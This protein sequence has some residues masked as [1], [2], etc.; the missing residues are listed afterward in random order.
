M[1]GEEV[2]L[3]FEKF[4]HVGLSKVATFMLIDHDSNLIFFVF[5]RHTV[6]IDKFQI[7]QR[8]RLLFLLE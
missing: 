2:E 6:L 7:L 4:P 3:S 1:G 5:S 8:L